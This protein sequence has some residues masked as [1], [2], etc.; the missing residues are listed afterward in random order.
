MCVVLQ[1]VLLDE[2]ELLQK[3]MPFI[4]CLNDF[5]MF[6]NAKLGRRT[7]AY[8]VSRMSQTQSDAIQ[9]DKRY[10]LGMYVAATSH[11]RAQGEIKNWHNEHGANSSVQWI[12]TF[13]KDCWQATRIKDVSV[14]KHEHELLMVP[15]SVI[16]VKR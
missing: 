13:P 6:R 7:V 2:L 1:V 5:L 15:Y 9:S 10:R 11:Q 4:R 16:H 14:H 3:M 8:R 12:F